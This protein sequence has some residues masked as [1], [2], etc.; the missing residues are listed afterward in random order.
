MLLVDMGANRHDEEHG[1]Q[2]HVKRYVIP[3][4]DDGLG[5]EI[6]LLFKGVPHEW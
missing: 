2:Q 3:I 6:I 4:C 1:V 5:D